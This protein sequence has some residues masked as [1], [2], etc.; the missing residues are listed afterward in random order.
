MESSAEVAKQ[1]VWERFRN[2]HVRKGTENRLDVVQQRVVHQSETREKWMDALVFLQK[3]EGKRQEERKTRRINQKDRG[4]CRGI[5][6]PMGS[7]Q[8][9]FRSY[10]YSQ[11]GIGTAGTGYVH[12]RL[13]DTFARHNY[14]VI[15]TKFRFPPKRDTLNCFLKLGSLGPRLHVT[16]TFLNL[17]S[18][19]PV[20]SCFSFPSNSYP[21]FF[22]FPLKSELGP[23][24]PSMKDTVDSS[25]INQTL[26]ALD[27]YVLL[28]KSGLRVSPLSLGT[29]VCSQGSPVFR[30]NDTSRTI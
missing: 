9:V 2:P 19:C 4:C 27:N 11:A 18:I 12:P 20:F 24:L 8:N 28:G 29:M 16:S 22:I 14:T 1:I 25:S 23:D 30:G 6:L 21:S 13:M 15:S 26:A 3:H 17:S 7:P 10:S 5:I